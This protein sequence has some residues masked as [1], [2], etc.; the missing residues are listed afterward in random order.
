[1]RVLLAGSEAVPFAK[2]GGLAD[3]LGALPKAL[4]AKGHDAVL[5]LPLY[6]SIDRAAL[7]LEKAKV[8]FEVRVEGPDGWREEATLWIAQLAPGAQAWFL[9]CAPLYGRYEPYGDESGDFADNAKRFTFFSHVVCQ[10]LR[11]PP[12]GKRFAATVRGVFER[13]KESLA[14]GRIGR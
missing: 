3:V 6:G 14:Y 5:V 4:A 9:E 11:A 12:D 8:R 2:T 1:M 7:G 10:I 13:F